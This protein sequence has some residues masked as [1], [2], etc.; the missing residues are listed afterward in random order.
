MENNSILDLARNEAMTAHEFKSVEVRDRVAELTAR[1]AAYESSA[2]NIGKEIDDLKNDTYKALAPIVMKLSEMNAHRAEGFKTWPQFVEAC[3][4]I[5]SRA[6]GTLITYYKKVQVV[7]ELAEFTVSNVEAIAPADAVAIRKAIES[8][9]ITP[10]TVQPKLKEFAK[11]HPRAES[12]KGRPKIEPEFI[13]T[14]VKTGD[15]IARVIKA[16]FASACGASEIVYLPA[17]KDGSPRRF[18]AYN[19]NGD[20][21]MMSFAPYIKPK[22]EKPAPKKEIS[23]YDQLRDQFDFMADWTDEQIAATLRKNADKAKGK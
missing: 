3:L 5:N 18:I 7:P 1:Y 2:K 19:S 9:E 22:A 12:G 14:N 4:P 17:P 15:T 11:A 21:V 16:D 13:L 20:C 8:G 23:V 6:A 10:N